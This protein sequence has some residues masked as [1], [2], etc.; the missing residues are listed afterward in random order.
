MLRT[1]RLHQ[2][3]YNNRHDTFQQYA[4]VPAEIV[5]KVG[6]SVS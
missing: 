2:G 1:H 5:A 3:S 6:R 4:V